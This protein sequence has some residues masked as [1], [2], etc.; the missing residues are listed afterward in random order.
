MNKHIT[1][2]FLTII[3]AA[4]T[5]SSCKDDLLYDPSVIGDGHA[6]IS[7]TVS[8]H[9]LLSSLDQTR[10]AGDAIKDIKTLQVVIYDNKKKLVNI[11]KIDESNNDLRIINAGEEGSNTS[12]PVNYGNQSEA[13]TAKASFKLNNIPFG[14]YYM[15]V[16]ANYA[17]ELQGYDENAEHYVGTPEDLKKIT[18]KW[19][20]NNISANDQMFG[21][22]ATDEQRDYDDKAPLITVNRNDLKLHAWIKRLAS[23][24][25]LVFDGTGLHQ[26]IFIYINKATIRDIPRYC[27]FGADNAPYRYQDENNP[28]DS[29]ISIG[30][31]LYYHSDGTITS[32]LEAATTPDT[33]SSG[34]GESGSED[35]EQP[36]DSGNSSSGDNSNVTYEYAKAHWLEIDKST[37]AGAA[38]HVAHDDGSEDVYT[39]LE[40]DQAL[41]F[42]ENCQGDYKDDP[43]Y[44]KKQ[45]IANAQ[46]GQLTDE[47][48]DE[49]PYGTYIEVEGYYTANY[50]GYLSNGKIVYRFMLGQDTRYNYN[51][52]R[53]RHYKLTLKFRGYAN[54]PDWHIEYEDK[55]PGLYPPEEYYM[56]YLYNVR[57]EMPIRLT[58]RATKVTM[59]IVENNWAP[60]DRHKIEDEDATTLEELVPPQS[61]GT[62]PM[63]FQ[64]NKEVY[65]GSQYEFGL[66][67][68]TSHQSTPSAYPDTILNSAPDWVQKNVTPIWVGFLALQAPTGYENVTEALP[69]GIFNDAHVDFYSWK[70]TR[71]GVKRYYYGIEST[72]TD[73]PA[74]SE[75]NYHK[76]SNRAS[77]N[78]IPLYRTVF[79][80]PQNFDAGVN[81]N[82]PMVYETGE[83]NNKQNG[84]NGFTAFPNED[85]SVTINVP[86]FTQPKD[87]G[88]I[89]GFSGNN[90]YEAYYRRAVVKITAEYDDEKVPKIIK[91]IPVYQMR[92]IIN[93]KAVWHTHDNTEPFEVKLMVVDDPEDTEFENLESNGEWAAWVCAEGND[94]IADNGRSIK[95]DGAGADGKLHGNTGEKIRF[96]ILFDEVDADKS[97]CNK[98]IVQYHGLNC[99]HSIYVRQGYNQPIQ[100]AEG[101]ARWS[102]YSVFSFSQIEG[103]TTKIISSDMRPVYE[104]SRW[105][106]PDATVPNLHATLTKSPLALGTLFKRGNYQQGIR[107]LNNKTYGP[108]TPPGVLS[109]TSGEED[110]RWSKIYGIPLLIGTWSSSIW[111]DSDKTKNNNWEWSEFDNASDDSDVHYDFPTI[112]DIQA[113]MNQGFGVGVL[114]TDG[115]VTTAKTTDDAFGFFNENNTVTRSYQGMRGFIVYNTTNHNQVF[116]PIGYSG[117][118]RR[119]IANTD[120]SMEGTLRYGGRSEPLYVSGTYGNSD[121]QYRPI[122]FNNP[123]CPGAIYWAK[124]AEANT[125]GGNKDRIGLDMNFF[126]LTFGPMDYAVSFPDYGDALPIKP[127]IRETTTS[128]SAVPSRKARRGSR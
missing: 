35:S 53:N 5:I 55:N 79:E 110:V 4:I 111:T 23:K 7:A 26:G 33:P 21:C 87:L 85:G 20:V 57:Q 37:V 95:I 86:M 62:G 103:Q 128:P 94:Y 96:K 34:E 6:N 117:L 52:L 61:V 30:E 97:V 41:Y 113:L 59:E 32:S 58:G 44:D 48:K 78:S 27:H 88:Y 51:A 125:P 12:M 123:A 76:D 15:Y 70:S 60:F 91:Y 14:R 16:V 39:H 75:H 93:P 43:R 92:R 8:F 17:G 124:R 19:N 63:R 122:P 1:Y 127:I 115:A 22:L 65:M 29:L 47:E 71:E 83:G 102:S 77:Y 64:W 116:F 73:L 98:I 89:S 45:T 28:N 49:V 3:I 119:T 118:A 42:Y 107:I 69:T 106:F 81:Y 80:I 126:D 24:L 101:G 25:T 13:S 31:T 38:T 109:L 11:L 82:N 2:I 99:E 74:L 10:S 40:G 120:A 9:P 56:S 72:L 121:N 84:R 112:A 114:Y 36:G 50:N 67:A 100:V 90:P 104:N 66:H 108:L 18:V 46:T 68:F 105:T 54:Q